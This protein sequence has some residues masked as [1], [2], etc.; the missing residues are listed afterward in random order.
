MRL[1]HQTVLIVDDFSTMRR[2]ISGLIRELGCER[3]VE[4]EDGAQA[5]RRLEAGGIDVVISDWNMP[6]MTG[7]ELLRRV[8][9]SE[10]LKSLPFLLVTAEGRKENIIEAAQ[11]GA[12]GYVV[13]PFTVST[14]AEKL[15]AI[16]H[17]RGLA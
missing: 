4:A 10:A 15:A 1:T 9:A 11:A 6:N 13:K 14:L 8:R 17:K 2:I 16:F 12:D 5:L 3:V 7:L